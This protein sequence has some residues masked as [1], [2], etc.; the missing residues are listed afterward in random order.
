[1]TPITNAQ[2]KVPRG[3]SHE[4]LSQ[5]AENPIGFLFLFAA[6]AI[7]SAFKRSKKE[8]GQVLAFCIALAFITAFFPSLGLVVVGAL[9][10]V[11]A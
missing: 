7:F 9:G 4:S 11:I 6:I 3:E 10:L 5:D 2:A 8:G 1:M